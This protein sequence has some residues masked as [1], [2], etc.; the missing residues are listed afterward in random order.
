MFRHYLQITLRNFRRFKTTFIINLV[1]LSTGLAVALLIYLWISGEL[2]VDGFHENGNRLY[3]VMVNRE[4]DGRINTV[5]GTGGGLGDALQ[6]DMPEVEYAVSMTPP[7]WFKK[8]NIGW[9]NEVMGASGNFVGKDYFRMFSFPLIRGNAASV[10]ADKNSVVLSKRLAEQLFRSADN[11]VGKTLEWKWLSFMKTC[12]VSGVYA[13]QPESST[14]QFDFVLPLDAW[15]DFVPATADFRSGPFQTFVVLKPGTDLPQFQ[16]KIENFIAQKD[17]N[18]PFP[19]RL[20]L[21]KYADGYLYGNYENGVQSGGRIEYVRLFSIIAAFILLIA[22]I[23]F[24]NLSTAKASRRMKEIGIKKAM[25]AGRHKLIFQFIGESLVMSFAALFIALLL[26]AL[27]LPQFDRIAGRAV[28]IHFSWQLVLAVLGITMAVGIVAGSYPAFYLSR[29]GVASILR[30]K[31]GG[32]Q[33]ESWV[34]KGLVAF[35][36]TVSIIFIVGAMVLYQQLQFVQNKQPG[37]DKD[38][39]IYFEMEG[40]V[41]ERTDAFLS[42]LKTIPGVVNASTVQQ[43]IIMPAFLPGPGVQWDGKNADDRIRFHKM[44]VNYDAL[45]TLGIEMAQGR[46]FSKNFGT[47]STGVILNQAAIKMM[48]ITDPVGKTIYLD[49]N[50]RTIIGVTKDFHYNSMHEQVQPF[51]FSLQ[52]QATAL[53]MVRMKKHDQPATISRMS[54]FYGRFNPGYTLNFNYMDTAYQ[55]QYTLEKL[56]ATLSRYFTVLA[57]VISCLGLLGLAAF[58]VERRV[59]EIGIRKV[60]GAS[61]G[62]I[63]YVLSAGFTKVVLLSIAVSIPISYLLMKNWLNGF[64]YRIALTPLYFMAAAIIALLAAWFTIGVQTAKAARANPLHCLKDE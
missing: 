40:R 52:P 39:V 13:D 47:D 57:I 35:Q 54:E 64:A 29:F 2:R 61:N 48:G 53:V 26:V 11:A 30:A 43:N 51:L 9:T 33:G 10:L 62:N 12:T 31:S 18:T 42:E 41:A 21:S 7:E 20:F 44:P 34:R 3:Q 17:K 16:Q 4:Q 23:N 60:L 59:K 55:Q 28:A 58:S 6:S 37:F 25:G 63:F 50:P 24:M 8:F 22:C 19:S 46:T 56:V 5:T 49:N 45:E 36:F 14:Q 15:K 38:N 27:F 32:G 1:G